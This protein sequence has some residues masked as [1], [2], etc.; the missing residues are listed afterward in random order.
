MTQIPTRTLND[1]RQMPVLGFGVF[2]V[3]PA[4]TPATVQAA[5][6]AGYR[7]IDTASLYR[8]EAEVGAAIARSGLPREELFITTK[9]GNP[10]QGY[11]STLRA[12]E[13]S[14]DRLGLEYVA[15]YLI[16]WPQPARDQYVDTWRALEKIAAEHRARSIGV[17]NFQPAHLARLANE[18]SVVP[19][20][21]QVELHPYLTQQ[22]LRA[23]HDEHGIITEAWSPIARGGELLA[24]P[25]VR[26]LSEK[27][28]KSPAQLVLRWHVQQDIVAIPRSVRPAR[29]AEN[30]AIFDFELAEDDLAELSALNRDAR[31][32]PDPETL[33]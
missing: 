17:S 24:D 16:H 3:D 31:I 26:A 8:N 25:A 1:G 29:I 18:T 12:F 28:G 13:A 10:D 4:E 21:N 6:E 15:L 5:L 30:F 33:G 11:D 23:Y 2:Q 19:A 9:L 7:S 20:V 27:Y 14:M 32:G 22:P